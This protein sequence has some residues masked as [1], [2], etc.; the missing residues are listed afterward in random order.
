MRNFTLMVQGR[1]PY[2]GSL[3]PVSVETPTELDPTKV[4]GYLPHDYQLANLLGRPSYWTLKSGGDVN[5][6]DR[7][8]QYPGTNQ[9]APETVITYKKGSFVTMTPA[10]QEF[11]YAQM[12]YACYGFFE[13]SKIPAADR[14]AHEN[15]W[16]SAIQGNRVMTNNFGPDHNKSGAVY[17]DTIR[18]LYAGNSYW[19][20][21]CLL[22]G[23]GIVHILD[24]KPVNR[25]SLGACYPFETLDWAAGPP[26]PQRV[27]YRTRPDL[28]TIATNI[29]PYRAH[30]TWEQVDPFP[31]FST[32]NAHTVFLNISDTGVNWVPVNRCYLT[33][34]M[35]KRPNPYN[36]E[37]ELR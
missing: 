3:T 33:D 8:R 18:N 35:T 17:H 20:H 23:G 5:H 29:A 31:Q 11:L 21:D 37:R 9:G 12:T 7:N 4:W 19:R 24:T 28:V 30:D 25:G 22:F 16:G 6:D 15:A 27:N 2:S 36:P 13:R 14:K 26:D 10:W 1:P 32:W 34:T